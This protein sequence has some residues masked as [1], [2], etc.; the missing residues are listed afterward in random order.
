[1]LRLDPEERVKAETVERISMETALLAQAEHISTIFDQLCS[2]GMD[3]DL[4]TD[5]RIERTRFQCWLDSFGIGPSQ[6]GRPDLSSKFPF[7][8]ATFV[9]VSNMMTDLEEQLTAAATDI[10]STPRQLVLPIRTLITA[11]HDATPRS[12]YQSA[13]QLAEIKML[14]TEGL[15]RHATTG[16]AHDPS[17]HHLLRAERV[18]LEIKATEEGPP[19]ETDA[20]TKK[21]QLEDV[22][23]HA[24]DL[25]FQ[26]V[27]SIEQASGHRA[28][29]LIEFKKY[30]DPIQRTKL[31]GR[32]GQLVH[33]S[34]LANEGQAPGILRCRGFYHDESK[35]SYGLVY[36]FPHTSPSG[37]YMP[38]PNCENPELLWDILEQASKASPREPIISLGRRFELAYDIATSLSEVHVLGLAYKGLTSA[39]VIFFPTSQQPWNSRPYIVGFRFARPSD[40][41]AFTEGPAND[42][43][44]TNYQHP[45]Y[46]TG[47]AR[48]RL[49]Y[50]YYSLGIILLEIGL[51][52]KLD[53]ITT[54]KGLSQEAVRQKLLATKLPMVAYTMGKKYR[55]VVQWCIGND[56]SSTEDGEEVGCQVKFQNDVLRPLSELSQLGKRGCL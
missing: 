10:S 14:G 29:V 20:S 43:A 51:W 15:A 52:R 16:Y 42:Q 55:A 35:G 13:Q 30:D 6:R 24:Y 21:Y 50:D 44:M 26:S 1:M 32:M 34:Q 48:Y 41:Q 46:T 28:N 56:L 18:K 39:N 27:G 11:L 25:K 8:F 9:N 37:T 49:P 4:L 2:K 3:G 22:P 47:V 53:R 45:L 33:I 40:H 23:V 38:S 7:N 54:L 36:D 19:T 31:F 5:P 12:F 17:S